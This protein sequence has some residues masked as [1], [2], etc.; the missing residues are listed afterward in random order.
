MGGPTNENEGIIV[1]FAV[2]AKTGASGT[3][4]LGYLP[5]SSLATWMLAAQE[6][7][8]CGYY[9]QLVAGNGQPSYVQPTG[10]ITYTTTNESSSTATSNSSAPTIPGISYQLISG[11]LYFRVVG[12]AGSTG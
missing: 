3:Y 9:G 12:V 4:Q 7:E 1:A 5:S 6:P 2:T 8:Q 10:C 11:D